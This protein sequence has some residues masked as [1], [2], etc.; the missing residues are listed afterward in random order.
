MPTSSHRSTLLLIASVAVLLGSRNSALG[1]RAATGGIGVDVEIA[2]VLDEIETESA[3]QTRLDA[4]IANL[5]A[6]RTALH[7]ALKSRVR[8]LYRITRSGMTPFA[9]GFDAIRQHV[10]RVRRL[11]ALVTNDARALQAAAL[12]TDAARAESALAVTSLE[13]ARQRL[14]ALQSQETLSS[15]HAQARDP[16]PLRENRSGSDTFYGLRLSDTHDEPSAAFEA[17]RGKLAAPVSGEVRVVEAHRRESDGTGLEFQ[18]RPGTSVRAAAAGRVAFSDHYGSYGRL[19]IIDHGGGYYT[20]YGGLGS[21][22]VRVGDDVSAY[23]RIGDIG[24][25]ASPAALYFEVRKGT[26][27]LPARAWLGL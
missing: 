20:A 16:S 11:Q 6:R 25:E 17:Q 1:E 24:S 22:E 3:K 15:L 7:Q 4:E 2:R 12:R 10:A 13:H 19:V 14:S 5:D 26:R 27:T 9:G 21:V 18:A 8:A 23:A